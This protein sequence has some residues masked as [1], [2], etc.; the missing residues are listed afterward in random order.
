MWLNST[1]VSFPKSMDSRESEG[2]ELATNT[3]SF[4][5]QHVFFHSGTNAEILNGKFHWFH[6]SVFVLLQ[7][8]WE[9]KSSRRQLRNRET[10]QREMCHNCT[11]Q[12]CSSNHRTRNYRTFY[13]ITVH[14]ATSDQP[15]NS[16]KT[17]NNTTCNWVTH[18]THDTDNNWSVPLGCFKISKQSSGV[19]WLPGAVQRKANAMWI[20]S[21]LSFT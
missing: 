13:P 1:W 20:S 8:M 11:A 9:D 2:Q 17:I 21:V 4:T 14:R 5:N 18:G 10:H 19:F 15:C 3:A 12:H 6:C 16:I 7:S